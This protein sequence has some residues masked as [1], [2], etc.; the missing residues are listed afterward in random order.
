MRTH[1]PSRP[2]AS[3]TLHTGRW[4]CWLNVSITRSASLYRSSP[5]STNTQCRRSPSTCA[6][7]FVWGWSGGGGEGAEGRSEGRWKGRVGERGSGRPSRH[8]GGRSAGEE[9]AAGSPAKCRP[10]PCPCPAP[11]MQACMRALCTRVAATVE[12]TPPD[13]AQMTWSVGPTCR[14]GRGQRG[15][16]PAATSSV[17]PA[18]HSHAAYSGAHPCCTRQPQAAR[19]PHVALHRTSWCCCSA[20]SAHPADSPNAHLSTSLCTLP[21]RRCD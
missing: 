4:R 15:E 13:R 8:A 19:V 10:C 17:A 9:W 16:A 3:S 5:L 11:G 6:H 12:S 14:A 2:P 20:P 1:C 7:G 18:G 21:P